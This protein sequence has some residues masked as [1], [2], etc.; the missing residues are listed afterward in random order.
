M[1]L[2]DVGELIRGQDVFWQLERE[3]TGTG[4]GG[5]KGGKGG[6]RSLH[7]DQSQEPQ[8]RLREP[9][10]PVLGSDTAMGGKAQAV[11][12]HHIKEPGQAWGSAK[13]HS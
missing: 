11:R 12:W 3:E 10:V 4:D 2:E 7:D 9:Q 1:D 5:R 8:C 13:R 6:R